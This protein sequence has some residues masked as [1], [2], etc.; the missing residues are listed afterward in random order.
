MKYKHVGY[1]NCL[2]AVMQYDLSADEIV[3]NMNN[4][5]GL[6]YTSG[7][8]ADETYDESYF[9]YPKDCGISAKKTSDGEY[10][11]RCD[12]CSNFENI[13]IDLVGENARDMF[14]DI[15]KRVG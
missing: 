6:Y 12:D 9:D 11:V 4:G 7:D 5:I 1:Y 3:E 8:D 10:L 13:P 2:D 15:Y 14:I